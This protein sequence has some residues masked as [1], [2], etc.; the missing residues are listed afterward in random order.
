[1]NRLPMFA[2]AMMSV[3]SGPLLALSSIPPREGELLL[4]VA[5]PWRGTPQDVV[6]RAGGYVVG[7]EHGLASVLATSFEPKF[8]G[9]LRDEGA[10]LILDGSRLV[11]FC[12]EPE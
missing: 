2:L 6:A 3:F 5:W 11:N 1:M 10:A 9:R 4:V 12:G 8:I 7:F